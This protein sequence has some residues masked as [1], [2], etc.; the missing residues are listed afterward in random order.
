MFWG[1]D[2]IDTVLQVFQDFTPKV[3]FLIALLWHWQWQPHQK[4]LEDIVT[5]RASSDGI[6]MLPTS[7]PESHFYCSLQI[8][9]RAHAWNIYWGF[10]LFHRQ[11]VSWIW[12]LKLDHQSFV[13]CQVLFPS[14]DS[15]VISWILPAVNPHLNCTWSTSVGVDQCTWHLIWH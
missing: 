4:V 1:G 7:F 13:L 10:L 3:H 9:R 12:M 15:K 14:Y 5:C 11:L 2:T 6:T 8:S